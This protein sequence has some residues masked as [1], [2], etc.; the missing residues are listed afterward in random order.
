LNFLEALSAAPS[1]FRSLA[2]PQRL[3]GLSTKWQSRPLSGRALSLC[4]QGT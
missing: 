2:R 4:G 3:S 1:T